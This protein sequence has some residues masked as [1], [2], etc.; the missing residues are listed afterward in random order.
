VNLLDWVIVVL[1]I[2]YAV[3]GFRNGA[4][5][6]LLSLLG[7]F[8]G[9]IIGVQVAVPLG[10]RL[11]NGR[12]QVPIAIVCVLVLAMVGQLVGVFIAN[13]VKSR[14]P[15]AGRKLDAGIGAVLGV[16]SVLLVAWMIAVPL[17]SSPYPPLAAEASQSTI[18]RGVDGVM[19]QS[20]RTLYSRLRTFLD[21]SGF[22]PVFGDLPNTSITAVDPPPRSFP[23]LVRRRLTAA[24]QSVFK[25][26]GQ[27][28]QCSRSIEGS[29]FVISPHH[30]MTNAHVVA[31]T[32]Q[33]GVVVGGRELAATVV[34]FDPDVDVAVLNVPG[35]D[36]A[37][38]RFAAQPA[39]TNAP[40]AVVGY[41]EDG[42][43]TVDAARVRARNAVTGSDIYGGPGVLRQVYSLRAVVRSGNSG[44]PLLSGTPGAAGAV[45]GVVF[46]TDLRSS[47]TGYALTAAQVAPALRSASATRAVSTQGC[48]AG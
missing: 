22:P 41:P 36:A 18:V 34:Y 13:R 10:S 3:T 46:A 43:L 9:A 26:Y 28:P 19:P 14:L 37:P 27:A 45:L 38:L 39:G 24:E 15:R 25:I 1:A 2:V 11:A 5:V 32:Q 21:R 33:L 44:G 17:A 35:L 42:P 20:M 30:L 16:L 31:G 4:V 7:F 6:G 47:D 48:A 12:A 8:A 40:A 29:G 23:T